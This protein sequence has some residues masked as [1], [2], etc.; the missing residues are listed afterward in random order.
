MVTL[1]NEGIFLV[2]GV[3]SETASVSKEEARKGTIAY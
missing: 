1:R 3:P 2:N